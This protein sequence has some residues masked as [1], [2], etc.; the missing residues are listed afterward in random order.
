VADLRGLFSSLNF[1]RLIPSHYP[2]FLPVQQLTSQNRGSAL[3][4]SSPL[5]FVHKNPT[6][7]ILAQLRGIL[8]IDLQRILRNARAGF[9]ETANRTLPVE[10]LPGY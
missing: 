7:V 9:L 8:A 2:L 3:R 1:V 10:W 4:G 6:T 5:V